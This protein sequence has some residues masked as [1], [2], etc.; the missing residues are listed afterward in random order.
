MRA[1]FALLLVACGGGVHEAPLKGSAETPHAAT[2]P[3]PS[4]AFVNDQFQVHG[5][6]AI[7]RDRSIAVLPLI[8]G[9]GGRGYP[10]LRIELRSE[11]DKTF[12]TD[13]ILISNDYEQLV[14]DGKPNA[15][16]AKRIEAVNAHLR[17]LTAQHDL[18]P[19]ERTEITDTEF[20]IHQT[21]E[22]TYAKSILKIVFDAG[23]S[24]TFEH[25]DWKAPQGARVPGAP[26]CENPE[27]LKAVYW[28]HAINAIVAEI[29]YQGTDTC[30]EPGNQLHVVTW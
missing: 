7:A 20:V 9:D 2:A 29:G 18:V 23:H 24:L 17:E 27:S 22:V 10:N 11:S 5:L 8:D 15:E 6:P 13:V 16:L 28:T 19:L 1:V 25:P 3:A 21:W 12:E 30:W 4:I 14:V 26:P